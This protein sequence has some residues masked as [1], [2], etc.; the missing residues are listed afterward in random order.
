M[1]MPRWRTR[2]MS[3]TDAAGPDLTGSTGGRRLLVISNG[4]GEDSI[5]AEIVRRLPPGFVVDAYPTLGPGRHYVGVC[6][7]VGPRAELASQGSR[8]DRG[9]VIG[10]IA[11]G[12]L[13]TIPPGL[14]F[15][16]RSRRAYDRHLVIGDIIG[17]AG[18]WLSG[19]RAVTYL[20]VY[21][22]G[23]GRPYAAIERWIVRQTCRTVFNRSERLARSLVAAGVDARAA[24]NVMMD[25]IPSGHYAATSRRSRP[26]AV[27]LLPGSRDRTAE[28]F[29]LQV[30][31]LARLPGPLRPDVF[32]AVAE[33]I[34][35]G[36]LAAAAGLEFA[37][38]SGGEAADLGTLA[39][40]GLT[41]HLAR[42]AFGNLLAATDL[43]LSQAG[44]ATIQALG[45]GKPVITFTRPTD[46]M[47][48]FLEENRLF[49]E[50]RLL[51]P[52]DA[53]ALTEKLAALL[54]DPAGIARLGAVGRERIG[55]PG[56]IGAI[57]EN[58]R[59]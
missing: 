38:P 10:D 12:G 41:V 33:G 7:I 8:V 18:C 34:E 47:K 44:T 2:P 27:T 19:V 21:K 3:A 49:G 58:L 46:R 40:R 25:T 32:A 55:G 30:G 20:D 48:R 56:A 45:S 1:P 5:G 57:I 31:A 14:A 6:P 43:V 42:G 50:A 35:I 51:V 17:V 26:L 59:G 9:T 39:G 29:A 37:P 15:M 54:A 11:A 13:A 24:G 28:N 16:R 53:T 4:I 22:T 36:A 23:Y 52:A